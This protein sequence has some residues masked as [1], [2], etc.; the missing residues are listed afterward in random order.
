[1]MLLFACFLRW[2]SFST[3]AL[4]VLKGLF[5]LHTRTSSNNVVYYSSTL[6][7]PLAILDCPQP[8]QSN[9]AWSDMIAMK[10]PKFCH[11]RFNIFENLQ[12]GFCWPS[13]NF[14]NFAPISLNQQW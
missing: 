8:N 1:V 6:C 2:I 4:Y 12:S 13:Y 7:P 9:S 5:C 11:F 14:R 10:I 3:G